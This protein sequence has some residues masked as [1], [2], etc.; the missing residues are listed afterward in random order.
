MKMPIRMWFARQRATSKSYYEDGSEKPCTHCGSENSEAHATAR[1]EKQCGER[2]A[3]LGMEKIKE[4]SF[5]QLGQ[6]LVSVKKS[7]QN[8]QQN[9]QGCVDFDVHFRLSLVAHTAHYNIV[10]SYV[11]CCG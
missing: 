3:A 6:T 9:T 10:D 11:T 4:C 8:T 1:H 5:P 2:F 7:E